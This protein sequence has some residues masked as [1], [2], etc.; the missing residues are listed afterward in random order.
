MNHEAQ[1]RTLLV[2]CNVDQVKIEWPG[3]PMAHAAM[4]GLQRH[5]IG[6]WSNVTYGMSHYH[7]WPEERPVVAD[8]RLV[9]YRS[10]ATPIPHQGENAKEYDA[11]DHDHDGEDQRESERVVHSVIVMLKCTLA[12]L[13]HI[14]VLAQTEDGRKCH[15]ESQ[16]PGQQHD[17]Q[18]G[19]TTDLANVEPVV[20][21]GQVAVNGQDENDEDAVESEENIEKSDN[22]ADLFHSMCEGHQAHQG[23]KNKSVAQQHPETVIDAQIYQVVIWRPVQLLLLHYGNNGDHVCTQRDEDDDSYSN[24]FQ[25]EI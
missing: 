4:N 11:G 1:P 17:G 19:Q 20:D 13:W 23:G 12:L 18:A 22:L 8:G 24:R 3:V 9:E 25:R 5:P 16:A 21:H 2:L 6:P 7:A 14:S 10:H 15:H